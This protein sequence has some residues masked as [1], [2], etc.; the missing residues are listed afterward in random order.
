CGRIFD[1]D[2]HIVPNLLCQLDQEV[3]RTTGV[4][5]QGR[6]LLLSGVCAACRGADA[7]DVNARGQRP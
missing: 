5:V 2:P 3:E 1:T 4:E 7:D 6:T